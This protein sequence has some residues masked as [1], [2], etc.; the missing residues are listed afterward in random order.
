MT[1]D[2]SVHCWHSERALPRTEWRRLPGLRL[3]AYTDQLA[4]RGSERGLN[5]ADMDPI[6]AWCSQCHC[7]RRTSFNTFEFA[8]EQH[9]TMFLLKWSS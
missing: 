7:G 3:Q 6:Q 9:I 4:P 5:E 8:S 1:V 2:L